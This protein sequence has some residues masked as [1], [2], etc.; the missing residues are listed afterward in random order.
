MRDDLQSILEPNTLRQRMQAM[1][2]FAPLAYLILCILRPIF[3]FP[4]PLLSITGGIVF[5][6]YWGTFYTIIGSTLGA[7]FSFAITRHFGQGFLNKWLTDKKIAKFQHYTQQSGFQFVFF[8][9]LI[10]GAPFDIISYAC[11]LSQVKFKHFFWGTF[12]GTIPG[13]FLGNFLGNS[14][15][16]PFTKEFLI[17]IV[18]YAVFGA[19]PYFFKY[20]QNKC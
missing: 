13:S 12:L 17:A 20:L 3:F 16:N 10:P 18:I 9:R 6:I 5:G 15:L 4:G 19:L 11:G 2:S 7:S 8:A 14:L 1:G